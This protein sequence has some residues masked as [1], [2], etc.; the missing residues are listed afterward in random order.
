MPLIRNNAIAEGD[1]WVH[2]ADGD[3]IG[4]RTSIIVSA[5]RWLSERDILKRS[6]VECGIRLA[7][8][9]PP[10]LITDDLTHVA[11]VALTFPSFKDGRAFTSARLLRDRYG[12]TGEVRAIGNVLRDQF[13]FM[14]RCGFDAFEVEKESDATAWAE[15]ASEMSVLYQPAADKRP[16]VMPMR[17]QRR[18]AVAQAALK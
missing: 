16:W 7:A 6:E 17:Q 11:L 1:R 13:Q 10:E 8:D 9:Q 2:L 15:K 18:A 12:F 4:K 3:G 5:I 14:V